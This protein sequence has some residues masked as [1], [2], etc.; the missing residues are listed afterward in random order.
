MC[1]IFGAIG[2]AGTEALARQVL[3]RLRHRG[4]D[5]EGIQR[6]A[7]GWLAH[8]RLSII[9]LSASGRQPMAN[10]RGTAWIA[11]NG[12]IYNYQELREELSGYPF[13][14]RT[15]TEVILAAYERWGDDCVRH[16]RGMFAFGLWDLA[17]RELF[18]ATDR[19]GIK[20]LYYAW[21]GRRFVFC[22]EVTPMAL[23]GVP[24]APNEQALYAYLACG[25]LDHGPDTLFEGI[26]QLRPGTT[27]TLH[28]GSLAIRRYW[29]VPDG[30][31][32][33]E[34]DPSALKA[35]IEARLLDAV[36]LHLRGDVE[37]GLSLSAGLDSTLLRALVLELDGRAA[38]L[39]CFTYAFPGTPYDEGP[40]ARAEA[41]D[42]C[43]VHAI[44]VRPERAL[45][46]LSRLVE[47]MEGPVGGLGIYGYWRSAQL[48]ADQGIKVL[49][50][51]QGA[52][53]TFAGYRY[54]YEAKLRQ[55][56]EQGRRDAAM[57]EFRQLCELHAEP[58]RRFEPGRSV[59]VAEAGVLAPDSTPLTST[60]AHPDFA[61]RARGRREDFPA[62]FAC[63]VKNAMYRDLV[64]L[65]IP[66]LL[67]FQDKCAM[68]WGV[69]VRVPYLDHPLV[70]A[71]FAA[72]T[73]RLLAA[74]RPK[75]L[76]R[77]IA[78]RYLSGDCLSAPKRYVAAPQREWIKTVWRRPIEEMIQDSVLAA[79]GYILKDALLSQFQAYV[80]SPALGNSFFIWKFVNLEL[81]YR[82]FCAASQPAGLAAGHP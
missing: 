51:G 43:R 55:L 2:R 39:Q 7:D 32:R 29:D 47:V 77:A 73:D 4:P 75:A 59:P 26:R 12:E 57:D 18:C 40:A 8:T 42:R 79:R 37:V 1:G 28:E 11:Y 45:E 56:W 70:E 27:L 24:L 61:A 38:P 30:E 72:P 41:P 69:E 36:R 9:D 23:C 20:P 81:W 22:S 34:E 53:E 25:L 67:R 49:L 76:L 44:D 21:D 17:R 15:D 50:D 6:F 10:A 3:E 52:D 68:A 62:P 63:A 46:E 66:K 19:F 71:L 74:G 80:D 31:D 65:K 48:A 33:R 82:R 5:D 60:Y 14:T 64:F 35:R 78:R 13:R 58:V 54:Y 16:L